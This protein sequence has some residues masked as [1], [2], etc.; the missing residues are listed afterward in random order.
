V[1][2]VSMWTKFDDDD[3]SMIV[4]ETMTVAVTG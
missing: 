1:D 2:P 4:T 3:V